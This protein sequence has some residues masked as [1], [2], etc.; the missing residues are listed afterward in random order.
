MQ[1]KYESQPFQRSKNINNFP[2]IGTG[3]T[4]LKERNDFNNVGILGYTPHHEKNLVYR[5]F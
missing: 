4:G 3:A 2:Q 1:S 5:D